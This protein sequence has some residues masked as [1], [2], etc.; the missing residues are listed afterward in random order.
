MSERDYAR[1][2]SY[3]EFELLP[4]KPL[5]VFYRWWIQPG[6][7]SLEEATRI[8][9]DWATPAKIVVTPSVD[10]SILNSN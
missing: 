2:G 3:F 7:L 1:F 5:E 10:A 9:A 8:A 6:E 4:E